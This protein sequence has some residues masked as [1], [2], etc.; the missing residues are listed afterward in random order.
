MMC[1]IP[2]H[3][4]YEIKLE[5]DKTFSAWNIPG[6]KDLSND[7]DIILPAL[8][9]LFCKLTKTCFKKYLQSLIFLHLVMLTIIFW[10]KTYFVLDSSS[11][12]QVWHSLFNLS[13]VILHKISSRMFDGPFFL[14]LIYFCCHQCWFQSYMANI[15]RLEF[16]LMLVRVSFVYSIYNCCQ[17]WQLNAFQFCIY[18]FVSSYLETKLKNR[19]KN[20]HANRKQ[21][22]KTE[23]IMFI[24]LGF[25]F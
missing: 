10:I 17:K 7:F 22:L 11:Q 3:V 24:P 6:L 1:Y 9:F 8:F 14:F 13:P 4:N 12:F 16:M 20:V 15:D 21:K 2:F 25:T 23:I 18:R 19:N 5:S